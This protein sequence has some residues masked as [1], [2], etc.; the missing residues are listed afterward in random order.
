MLQ[1]NIE[2]L[3]FAGDKKE[4]H[5][6][7][8]VRNNVFPTVLFDISRRCCFSWQREWWYQLT[9]VFSKRILLHSCND[10]ARQQNCP[11]VHDTVHSC[12]K[13]QKLIISRD[14]VNPFLGTR[15]MYVS[16]AFDKPPTTVLVYICTSEYKSQENTPPARCNRLPAWHPHLSYECFILLSQ[17]KTNISSKRHQNHVLFALHNIFTGS[18]ITLG[19]K[20]C[21]HW[22][23]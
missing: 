12:I 18:Q 19:S 10:C 17:K 8:E 16:Q 23:Q 5:S 4:L 20:V 1:L 13:H 6:S 14:A 7:L 11:R 21:K 2:C 3:F 9:S 15:Y 22:L